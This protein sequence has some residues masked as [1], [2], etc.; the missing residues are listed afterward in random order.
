MTGVRPRDR[1]PLR[2]RDV[3]TWGPGSPI[4]YKFAI[5][6]VVSAAPV[7]YL[8]AALGR[9]D[10]ALYTM[11]GSMQ[12]LFGHDRA[13]GSRARMLAGLTAGQFLAVLVS[14]LLSAWAPATI[15][16]IVA[17]AVTVTVQKLLCDAFA[18]GPPA[19]AVLSF[20]TLGVMFG[21]VTLLDDIPRDLGLY[22]AAAGWAFIVSMA[23]GLWNPMGPS[24]NA[25]RDAE[26]LAA[27]HDERRTI[28]ALNHA[29]DM[30]AEASERTG[31]TLRLARRLRAAEDVFAA[32]A[33]TTRT[34]RELT[35]ELAV[36]RAGRPSHPVL[37]RLRPA[38]P[39][40]GSAALCLAGTTIG[41]LVALA[42]GLD[43][44]YWAIVAAAAVYRGNTSIVW[45]RALLRS[46]GTVGG[47]LIYAAIAP[48]AALN[49]FWLVT[50]TLAAAFGIEAFVSRNYAVGNLFV[51]PMALLMTTFAE[52]QDTLTL[53]FSRA[54][55][56]AI[57]ALLGL[58]CALV[59]T[60]HRTVNEVATRV[61]QTREAIAATR[62]AL[63]GSSTDTQ[64]VTARNQLGHSL[65]ALD[66]AA[67]DAAGEWATP[68]VAPAE[69]DA[70]LTEGRSVLVSTLS[71]GDPHG[72]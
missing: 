57:G 31:Q 71:K 24:E 37:G 36:R 21:P 15:V 55:D 70:V 26:R 30:L 28:P 16:L 33:A 41:G 32:R 54:A 6:V 48:T 66:D 58:C 10:L 14:L 44:P 45:Q 68:T 39:L 12:A 34:D 60:N 23:P 52:P 38:S 61:A 25:V 72:E 3:L 18:V 69:I 47:V 13:Y 9:L 7:L 11:V 22:L 46:A 2:V 67:T 1:P 50:L 27:L 65:T 19:Q 20:I 56:T 53:T 35:A 29:W 17:G 40:W 43:R 42:V 64:I 8:L 4:W 59:F 5:S 62:A 51:A 63:T 49:T